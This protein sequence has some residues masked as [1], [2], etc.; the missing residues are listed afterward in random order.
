MFYVKFK[1]QFKGRFTS[2]LSA[3]NY[4]CLLKSINPSME[5]D[6]SIVFE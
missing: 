6:L 5:K 3:M 1:N 2:M 4:A